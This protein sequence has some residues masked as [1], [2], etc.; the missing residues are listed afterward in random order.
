MDQ[1]W[2]EMRHVRKR[3]LNSAVWIP[4]RA[5]NTVESVGK[6]GFAGYKEDYFGAG[7]LAVPLDAVEEA[8]HVDWMDI[9]V[10]AC[11]KPSVSSDTYEPADVYCDGLG[12]HLVLDQKVNQLQ[13]SVWHLHQDL[14]LALGLKRESDVW[15]SPNEGYIEVVRLRRNE[16]GTAAVIEIRAEF[17]KDYLCA[18]AMKLRISSYRSRTCTVEDASHIKWDTLPIEE[19]SATDNWQG[20]IVDIHEGGHRFGV[21]TTV[22]HLGRSAVDTEE[23]VPVYGLPTDSEVES[24]KR[25]I[26]Y[27]GKKLF[28]VKGELWRNEWIN[29]A[30]ASQRVRRDAV[31][32]TVFFI[33]D[34]QG[35]R[36]SRD[37]LVGGGR[38]LWFRPDVMM[39]L[40]HRRGGD[41]R[42][43]TRDTGSVRCSP[44]DPVDFGVNRLGLVNVYAK[45]IALLPDWQQQIWAG[46]NVAPEGGVSEELLSSQMQSRP[47]DT[48]APEA[49]LGIGLEL[50]AQ[51]GRETYGIELIRTHSQATSI[52]ER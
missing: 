34:A 19:H 45:D 6:F 33:T 52:L 22:I 14:V 24:T 50:V 12:V 15:V 41:L 3:W 7:S 13:P 32:A 37:T 36:E 10:S 27:K 26:I 11:H 49:F 35:T 20:G 42:W 5:N 46:H 2:F 16:D 21:P 23:D 29:P 51:T 43:Y 28:V 48:Q 39:S 17:L 25:K 9:G 40:A 1:S 4:L 47:A 31:P 8:E 30:P 38:W 18:R 44:D